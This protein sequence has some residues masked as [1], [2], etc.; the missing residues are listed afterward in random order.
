MLYHQDVPKKVGGVSSIP[1][2]PRKRNLLFSTTDVASFAADYARALTDGLAA[3]GSDHISGALEAVRDTASRDGTIFIGG[4]GGSA[5][6]ADHFSCDLTKGTNVP[7]R[8]AIRSYSLVANTPLLMAISNDFGY[9]H[10]LSAQLR[11]Q[12]RQQDLAILISASG[13]SPNILAAAAVARE[14]GLTT[15]GMTGFS[16][17]SLAEAVDVLLHVPVNNYGVVEDAHQALIHIITQFLAA[18]RDRLPT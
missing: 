17:G 10:S 8:S 12:A 7:E 16:G 13:N 1:P 15:I 6:L 11:M 18:E 14:L 4:N 9:E 5:A 3:V 2:D